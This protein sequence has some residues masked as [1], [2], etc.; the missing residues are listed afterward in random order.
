M[1]LSDVAHPV[2]FDEPKTNKIYVQ[3]STELEMNKMDSPVSGDEKPEREQWGGKAEFLLACLGNAVG[4]GNIW[5]FPYLAYKNGGGAFVI[6]YII[7]V[8]LIGLPLFIVELSLGQFSA[9]GPA[10][11]YGNLAPIFKG[12]G[13]AS[14]VA[15]FIVATYYNM[16]L[17]WTLNYLVESFMGQNWQYC[18][19][20]HNTADC[21]TFGD[22]TSNVT[23]NASRSSAD[24]FFNNYILSKSAG[25]DELGSIKWSLF[26]SL[27]VA[28]IV[29]CGALIKGI[30]SSGIY[31]YTVPDMKKL[32]EISVWRDAAIQVFYS[33]GIAGGGMLTYASYNKFNEPIRSSG[34][35][36]NKPVIVSLTCLVLFLLGIPY[37]TNGGLYILELVDHYAAG[38]PY[39]CIALMEVIIVAYTYGISPFL[40]D[41]HMMTAWRPG[42]WTR[43]HFV[44]M[45]TT[46]CPLVIGVL[47][48]MDLKDLILPST[49]FSSG[50]YVYPVWTNAAG[51]AAALIPLLIIPLMAIHYLFF[52]K[53]GLTVKDKLSICLTPTSL[54]AQNA[55]KYAASVNRDRTEA[56]GVPNVTFEYGGNFS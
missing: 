53:K 36:V 45:L 1:S 43:S 18:G 50:D 20:E 4:L 44:V 34:R 25:V 52:D 5:R 33:F 32:A 23:S 26:A 17:A 11:L 2:P 24:E 30:Q 38:F 10:H 42:L 56:T 41:L 7:M 31:F 48:I 37:C 8:F 47:L 40:K 35:E 39:L 22:I 3:G 54:Y 27:L 19:Q 12:V 28:W 6:P 16:I 46:V 13:F 55:R 29:V 21:F 14:I 51:W 15:A 49:P 9:L